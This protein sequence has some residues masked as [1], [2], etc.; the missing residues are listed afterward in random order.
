[1]SF[2]KLPAS[3]DVALQIDEQ[4]LSFHELQQQ[5]ND[6]MQQ[7][8]KLPDAILILEAKTDFTF[9]IH[10]LA[11]LSIG[12]PM[13]LIPSNC[14]AKERETRLSVLGNTLRIDDQ[15][16]L[17]EH[18][19]HSTRKHHPQLALI[20]FTSGSTGEVKAV[21]LSAQNIQ[22]NCQAVIAALEFAEIRDQLLF[23]PLSYSFGLLG[24]LLPGLMMGIRTQ[25]LTEFTQ[26]KEL[27]EQEQIPDMWSGVPS[28]WVAISRMVALYPQSASRIKKIISAGASLPIALRQELIRVFPNAVVY[29]NYGLTEASP[30]VLTYS[31]KDP[32]FLEDYAGYPV[33]DWQIQLSEHNE[34][35]IRGSQ[36]MLGYL[37]DHD[38][39][40]WLATGD[41]ASVNP[42]GL[43]AIQGRLDN[44]VNIGGE[45]VNLNEMEQKLGHIAG[46]NNLVVLACA[47][48]LY[49]SSL[50]VCVE[51]KNQTLSE[52]QLLELMQQQ[53][54]PKKYPIKLR[55]VDALP[56]NQHGKF[57]RK[58]LAALLT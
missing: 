54:L 22:A 46:I 5:L 40:H 50:L 51:Q 33:G 32:L 52:P 1:M 58:Q 16:Q 12:Q 48:E 8:K 21:Q 4:Q 2:L 55:W 9:I 56:C 19:E 28:H 37:N 31:S 18:Q 7:L 14:A 42:T 15:G 20:L 53:L 6:R 23:L 49:G 39:K 25:L 45:K 43:V 57:N 13:A 34:L 38:P 41:R 30:R 26:I 27:L 35:L 29:N 24:Q 36:M 47:D 3:N 10:F 11:A 44:V 17:I